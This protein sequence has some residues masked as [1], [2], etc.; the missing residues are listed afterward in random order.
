MNFSLSHLLS[1]VPLIERVVQLEREREKTTVGVQ[2]FR[3]DDEEDEDGAQLT[4]DAHAQNGDPP[5]EKRS[6]VGRTKGL[7]RSS[8]P[9]PY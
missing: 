4:G 3:D 8:T 9:S 7:T 1:F 5:K 2:N 6:P